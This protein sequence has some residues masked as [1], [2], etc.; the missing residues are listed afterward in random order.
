MLGPVLGVGKYLLYLNRHFLTAA[1]L[2]SPEPRGRH[3]LHLFWLRSPDADKSRLGMLWKLLSFGEQNH[4]PEGDSDPA[5][6]CCTREGTG[7]RSQKGI[8]RAAHSRGCRW[9]PWLF[10]LFDF[11]LKCGEPG[12]GSPVEQVARGI[13]VCY[14]L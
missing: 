14:L 10:H 4:Q 11:K 7:N 1:A 13:V 3:P 5:L 12:S 9:L 8:S 6:G 2:A